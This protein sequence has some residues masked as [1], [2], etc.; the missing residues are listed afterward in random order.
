[1]VQMLLV[2]SLSWCRTSSVA[3]MRI[4]WKYLYWGSQ[5]FPKHAHGAAAYA[6]I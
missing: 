2:L 5:M 1:M 3:Q 6:S 4:V